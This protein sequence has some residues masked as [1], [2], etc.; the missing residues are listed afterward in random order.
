MSITSGVEGYGRDTRD[1]SK[2]ALTFHQKYWHQYKEDVRKIWTISETLCHRESYELHHFLRHDDGLLHFI[3]ICPWLASL[4]FYVLNMFPNENMKDFG[5][6]CFCWQT[7][8]DVCPSL[9]EF[10]LPMG[11]AYTL[12]LLMLSLLLGSCLF[13]ASFFFV[14]SQSSAL[15]LLIALPSVVVSWYPALVD[16]W[17]MIYILP[18]GIEVVL[19]VIYLLT[20]WNMSSNLLPN[21]ISGLCMTYIL[22]FCLCYCA[23]FLQLLDDDS[24]LWH[25]PILLSVHQWSW[26]Q[27]SRTCSTQS[28]SLCT[29]K[30][31][32]LDYYSLVIC[33]SL[34]ALF[35]PFVKFVPFNN[36]FV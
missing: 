5:F 22:D 2:F 9:S 7:L 36:I 25:S 11:L 6:L 34:H 18:A 33:K 23:S 1:A 4:H 29:G 30:A 13:T 24:L 16:R 14:A 31:R 32:L 10:C 12:P 3:L 15:S 27:M 26:V 17:T 21:W 28:G 8:S 20:Y 35:L 19:L